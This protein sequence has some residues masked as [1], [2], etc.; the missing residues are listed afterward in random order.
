MDSTSADPIVERWESERR[1]DFPNFAAGTA[2]PEAAVELIRAD[3]A[4][5]DHCNES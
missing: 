3:D 4:R 5:G 2:G 1:G